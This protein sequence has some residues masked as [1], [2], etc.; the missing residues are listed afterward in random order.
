MT[1]LLQPIQSTKT[2]CPYCGVGCGVVVSTQAGKIIEVKGDESHPANWGKLC[3]KGSKL[4]ETAS[5]NVYGQVRAS[6]P[7]LRIQRDQQVAPTDW[8]TALDFTAREFA[9]LIATYGPDSIGFYISGQLLTEDYYVFNKLAKGLIG[10]NNIDTNSRL[11]MSSAVSGYKRTLG[12]D[13]PP[14]NYDDLALADCVFIAGSNMAYAHPVAYH[15]LE[16]ARAAKL[17]HKLIVVDPRATDTAL[18]ADL[19]LKIQPGTDVMLFNAMLH[20]MMQNG[21]LDMAYINQHT[22][23]FEAMAKGLAAYTPK[24]AASVCAVPEADIVL[25]ATWF[26]QSSRTL[27]L[28]CQGLNQAT[29]G[30]DKNTSLIALHLA[31]GQIGK[32][33]SGPFSLTGQPNAMGGR[34]VGG[35]S[36]LLPAHRELNNPAHVAE[37]AA[38]WGV[39]QIS[40][41]PGAS[42]V[43]MFDQLEQGK[44]KAV[45]V[46]CTNPAHS[47]PNS[48]KVARAMQNAELVVVQDAYLTP[49]TVQYAD[50][51]LPATTW[52]EKEGTV[53]NSERRISRVLPAMPAYADS[54]NDWQIVVEFAKRLEVEL[55]KLGVESPRINSGIHAFMPYSNTEE[56]FNEHRETTRGLDLDITGLSY[57]VLETKGPQQWPMPE[58]V[59]EGKARLYEDGVYPTATGKAKFVFAHY[60]PVAEEA[61]ARFPWRLNT[62][63]LRDQWHGGSRTG[64]LAEFFSHEAE[65]VVAMHP[66]DF[67]RL[68]LK[69]SSWVSVK[70]R[71]ATITLRA[72]EDESVARNQAVLPMHWGPEFFGGK[73]GVGG[74]NALTIE[75]FDP[76]SKQPELKHSAVNIQRVHLPWQVVVFVYSEHWLGLWQK[77]RALYSEF[78]AAVCVPVGREQTGVL[79]RAASANAPAKEIIDQLQTLFE[80]D[81]SDVLVY[82]D[83]KTDARRRIGVKVAGTPQAQ[84]A[85]LSKVFLAGN[86]ESEGWLRNYF[87]Q[88]LDVMPIRSFL[89]APASQPPGVQTE[90]VRMVCNCVGVSEQSIQANIAIACAKTP[91]AS[92]NDLLG[93]LQGTLKC[94]TQCGSCAPEI[95]KLIRAQVS[96]AVLLT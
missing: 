71:R 59:S 64:T 57:A 32:E 48:Q 85:T 45:W 22:E 42:A 75:A 94:G 73:S 16:A 44:I 87:D 60:E 40:A 82:S 58:G 52:G 37:V 91:N 17:G 43:E 83:P 1:E 80:C 46:A 89:L 74:V 9:R 4:A 24:L 55:K 51:L 36:T 39:K 54:K 53:T 28:Y 93:V 34:E 27:S 95:R 14:C 96:A 78:D 21:W 20:V 10:T 3:S 77:A 35:L 66:A 29:T 19:H 76:Y 13:A 63:R 70:S 12:A 38:F 86:I 68:N 49:A 92:E 5:E 90:V 69:P 2:T 47:L 8:N 81:G 67:K 26:A 88:Q 50:V 72:K 41:T 18:M 62:G 33:G 65:P 6:Q 30:T 15:R 11:C 31:T 7:L 25:A 61:D 79:F 84:T 56:I 23:G